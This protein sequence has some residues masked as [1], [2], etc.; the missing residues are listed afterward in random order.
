[1]KVGVAVLP[2]LPRAVLVVTGVVVVVV[3]SVVVALC[4]RVVALEAGIAAW[5]SVGLVVLLE[6]VAARG[7]IV[8][9]VAGPLPARAT[10]SSIIPQLAISVAARM[11]TVKEAIA[12]P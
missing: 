3:L 9:P 5:G 8:L 7:A 4:P 11:M 2:K 1:M 10:S 12:A 6:V